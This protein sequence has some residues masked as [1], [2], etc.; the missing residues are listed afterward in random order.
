[1]AMRKMR[2]IA[3]PVL[4]ATI[5]FFFVAGVFIPFIPS[6]RWIA[7][8]WLGLELKSIYIGGGVWAFWQYRKANSRMRKLLFLSIMAVAFLVLATDAL[9]W[10]RPRLADV[11][12]HPIGTALGYSFGALII[13]GLLAEARDER[14]RQNSPQQQRS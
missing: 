10:L 9:A 14:R 13:A 2:H 5:A 6:L 3:I 1:M 8:V 12:H 11:L 7:P 4:C